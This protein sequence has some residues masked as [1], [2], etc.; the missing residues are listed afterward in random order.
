MK[1][2]KT[3]EIP[4]IRHTVKFYDISQLNGV[5]I[6]GSGYTSIED[7]NTTL[8]FF[9]DIKNTV[10]DIKLSAWVAHELVHV[11]QII[12]EKLGARFEN[13]QEHMA[14]IMHYLMSELQL[15]DK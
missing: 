13:E 11:L 2:Y 8:V 15:K 7:E 9:E 14:Y 5:E 12:C 4:H 6:K 10:N 3:I 1:P